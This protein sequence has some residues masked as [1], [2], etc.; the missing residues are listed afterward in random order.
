MAKVIIKSDEQLFN[1][2]RDLS[3]K[4]RSLGGIVQN[5]MEIEEDEVIRIMGKQWDELVK[6]MADHR[7]AVVDHIMRT[8][9][10]KR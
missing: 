10:I 2:F 3:Y 9:Q 4:L 7:M 6:E 1:K 8:N 5:D